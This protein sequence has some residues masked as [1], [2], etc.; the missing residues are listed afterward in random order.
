[1][2]IQKGL[3]VKIGKRE[4]DPIITASRKVKTGIAGCKAAA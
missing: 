1:V 3:K 4:A 2:Q